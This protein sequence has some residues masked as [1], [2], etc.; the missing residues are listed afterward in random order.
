MVQLDPLEVLGKPV[1]ISG[2][3]CVFSGLFYPFQW[4]VSGVRNEGLPGDQVRY[5]VSFQP[6]PYPLRLNTTSNARHVAGLRKKC[7]SGSTNM[8]ES[9][10]CIWELTEA[11]CWSWTRGHY[12]LEIILW[13]STT[14]FSQQQGPLWSQLLITA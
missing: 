2:K 7:G 4:P 8:G 6:L 3:G 11:A 13:C 5:M 1:V 9:H 14:S 10:F 12:D